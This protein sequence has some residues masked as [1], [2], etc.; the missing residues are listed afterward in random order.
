MICCSHSKDT[1]AILI[2]SV[3]IALLGETEATH[4]TFERLKPDVLSYVVLHV[5][6]LRGL[7]FAEFA[8]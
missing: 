3:S 1:G 6:E 4:R 8:L 2:V 7:L 5:V